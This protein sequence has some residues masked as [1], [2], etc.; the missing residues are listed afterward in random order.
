MASDYR[1]VTAL[2]TGSSK[3]LGKALALELARRGARL[4]LVA[5]SAAQLG[6]VATEIRQRYGNQDTEV[7]VGDL[8]APGG[9]QRILAE[10]HDRGLTV[11][12]LVNNAGAG[13]AGAFLRRPLDGQLRSVEL[14]VNALLSLTHAIGGELIA[15]GSGGIINVSSV[16]GFQPMPFQATYAASKAFVLSFSES[17]AEELRGSGVRVMAC[18][19]GPI[20]TG[21]FDGTTATMQPNADAPQRIAARTLDD[22]AKGRVASYPGGRQYRAVTWLGRVLPR[23]AT[24]RFTGTVNRR[25]HFDEVVDLA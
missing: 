11:D 25:Q 9:P 24:A 15:R 19:P 21:F 4:I 5:R 16:A 13:G 22:F 18:H 10:L 17:L 8:I 20:D 3:G 14:N 1:G 23:V 7:I 6:E 2:V 12:L